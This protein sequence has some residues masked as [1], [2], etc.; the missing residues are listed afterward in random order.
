[1][2]FAFRRACELALSGRLE[3][4]H[5]ASIDFG[6]SESPMPKSITTYQADPVPDFLDWELYIGPNPWQP[7]ST[8]AYPQTWRRLRGLTFDSDM[9]IHC[10]PAAQR[11]LGLDETGPVEIIGNGV[12]YANG[13][14]IRTARGPYWVKFVG[15]QGWAG[16]TAPVTGHARVVTDPPDW[17]REPL[18]PGD[19]HLPGDDHHHENFLDCIRTRR[20]C[21]ADA[22]S[23]HRAMSLH[24]IRGIS[25]VTRAFRWDP[26]KEIFV[27]ENA[28]RANRYLRRAY[29]DPWRI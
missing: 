21:S 11:G 29:R 18:G 25:R 20:K 23:H 27:G 8:R 13:L 3:K 22:E 7:F 1:M 14:E 26:E 10:A 15:D 16:V 17:A 19:V 2:S 5:Y 4:L 12:R 6:L 28:E 24:M 9:S